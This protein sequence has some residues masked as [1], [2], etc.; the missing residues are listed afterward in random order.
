MEGSREEQPGAGEARPQVPPGGMPDG[1]AT[2]NG[3]AAANRLLAL[4]RQGGDRQPANAS[5]GQGK[6]QGMVMVWPQL[7]SIEL[8]AVLIF[9][10][11]LL[12]LGTVVNAPLDLLANPD[13][14]PNP[15]KA[16]WYFLNLQ[17]LLLHMHPT[18]AGVIVPG[19]ALVLLAAIPYIDNTPQGTGRWFTTPVGKSIAL[20]SIGYALVL[21]A[22]M[23]V[24]DEFI[25]VRPLI[26]G[27][28]G[29]P[30]VVVE[31]IIPI[32]AMYGLSYLLVVLV[33]RRYGADKRHWLIALF[34]GFVATYII[35]TIVGTAF[36]GPGMHLFL[37]WD[38][39]GRS[40]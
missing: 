1:A 37:P 26:Q 25:G 16:P 34:S 27:A 18:L 29:L 30:K 2:P 20:F 10:A 9:T 13:R 40:H 36:R 14:T 28:L 39:A 38:T 12:I 6:Q 19:G 3:G 7:V 4:S 24:L 11:M 15:S 21:N 8:V 23:I 22:L 33:K 5:P 32:G 17:E 31:V 35:L